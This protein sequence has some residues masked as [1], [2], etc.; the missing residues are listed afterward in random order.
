[1]DGLTRL[2]FE[3][4]NAMRKCDAN[5]IAEAMVFLARL[6]EEGCENKYK[7]IKVN[8]KSIDEHRLIMEKHL[9]RK[10]ERYEVVHHKNG[11]KSDNRIENLEVMTLSEHTAMHATG[12]VPSEETRKKYSEI[13]KGRKLRPLNEQQIENIKRMSGEGKSGRAIARETGIYRKKV[14][15]VISGKY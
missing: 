4:I 2:E 5:K 8:G 9:G 10:L 14:N 11:I 12:V 13:R 3:I 1:M 6:E 7:K 15:A